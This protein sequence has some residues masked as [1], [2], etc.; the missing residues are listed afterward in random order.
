M[1]FNIR[2]QAVYCVEVEYSLDFFMIYIYNRTISQRFESII[3]A[4][5]AV[6][7]GLST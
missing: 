7:K 4:E 5:W 2:M 1:F 3:T 6:C